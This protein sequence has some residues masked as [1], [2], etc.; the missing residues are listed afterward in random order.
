LGHHHQPSPPPQSPPPPLLTTTT[1]STAD[2]SASNSSSVG[3]IIDH[4][5]IAGRVIIHLHNTSPA[6][7]DNTSTHFCH[8]ND[9][10]PSAALL[11]AV[12]TESM[13]KP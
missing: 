8:F 1:T 10:F 6:Q 9:Y 7:P 2:Y 3:N 11:P 13:A 5:G 4:H 12:R